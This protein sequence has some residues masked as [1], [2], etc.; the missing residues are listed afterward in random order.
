M[1]Q[2]SSVDAVEMLPPKPC[3]PTVAQQGGSLLWPRPEKGNKMH[4]VKWLARSRGSA[5]AWDAGDVEQKRI[6]VCK[7][8]AIVCRAVDGDVG[9]WN[10]VVK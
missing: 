10:A 7:A 5:G 6:K 1:Q 2:P 4:E 3:A 8:H 9:N